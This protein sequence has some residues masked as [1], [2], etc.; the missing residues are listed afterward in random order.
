MTDQ[1]LMQ[2]I[3]LAFISRGEVVPK[4]DEERLVYED[5][6]RTQDIVTDRQVDI[7][8]QYVDSIPLSPVDEEVLER[9]KQRVMKRIE[10][11]IYEDQ[12]RKEIREK[13]E[14]NS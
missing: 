11:T 12:S 1:E 14:E 9:I 3:R 2:A 6:L 7:L 8:E 13:N 10:R 4:T 5:F